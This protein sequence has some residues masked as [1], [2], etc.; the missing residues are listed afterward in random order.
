[1]MQKRCPELTVMSGIAI[2]FVLSIHACGSCLG[3]LYPGMGYASTDTFLLIFDNLITPAVPMFLF[4]SGFKY[5]LRDV[6]T[7]YF[8]FLKKRLPRVLMSFLIINTLFWIIDS[9][10]WMDHFDPLL[11]IKTYVSSWLGNTVAYPLW[12]I[13]MYCCVIIFCPL[14]YRVIQKS[15][16]RLLLYLVIGCAQRVLAVYVPLLGEYPFLFVSYPAFFELG[17]WTQQHD[18]KSKLNGKV[19]WISLAFI[20]LVIIGSVGAPTLSRSVLVQYLFICV[21]GTLSYYNLAIVLRNSKILSWLGGYSYP[22]FLLHEPVIGRLS[23]AIL[24]KIGVNI[25]AVYVVLWGLCVFLMTI[26]LIKIFE[27]LKIDKILWKFSIKSENTPLL[28]D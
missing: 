11:L 24:Q 8:V 16:L 6:E 13:P 20:G 21:F 15:W 23:G 17:I 1:M 27:L 19:L 4:V 14:M 12:Y 9:I 2:V 26:L 18:L 22:L 28:I 10:I 5:A 7:P 25:S 3:Y